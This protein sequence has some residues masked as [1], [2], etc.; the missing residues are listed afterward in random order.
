MLGL[1]WVCIGFAL[2]SCLVR[3]RF[4]LALGSSC[5]VLGLVGFILFRAGF[6][7]GLVSGNLFFFASFPLALL[8]HGLAAGRI[9]LEVL[10]HIE[11]LRRNDNAFPASGQ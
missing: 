1:R 10:H 4:V 11:F 5:F 7:F 6:A 8:P 2:G 9:F 3:A